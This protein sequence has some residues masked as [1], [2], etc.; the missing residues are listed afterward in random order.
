MTLLYASCVTGV[1]PIQNLL[2]RVTVCAG[3]SLSKHS[4]SSGGQPIRKVPGEIQTYVRPSTRLTFVR[5][6]AATRG[7]SAPR[8][9][10][11]AIRTARISSHPCFHIQCAHRGRAMVS[12]L[13]PV[14]LVIIYIA[15]TLGKAEMGES[16]YLSH[17]RF[18]LLSG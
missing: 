17:P 10:K 6:C 7:V 5:P 1:C 15:A 11:A 12:L 18:L 9:A 13:F 8:K 3:F 16:K 2:V 14:R 4:E